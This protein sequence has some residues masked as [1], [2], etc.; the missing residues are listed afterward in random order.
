MSSPAV[1]R[2]EFQQVEKEI[3]AEMANDEWRMTNEI[4]ILE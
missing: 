4:R 2:P 1:C 3:M